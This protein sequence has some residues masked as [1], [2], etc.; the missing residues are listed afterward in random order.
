MNALG[1]LGSSAARMH[2]N[3]VAP[4]LPNNSTNRRAIN[5][6]PSVNDTHDY[7]GDDG[8]K[9]WA[10]GVHTL[11]M[12]KTNMGAAVVEVRACVQT[13]VRSSI[14]TKSTTMCLK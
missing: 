5:M 2:S 1:G 10:E 11:K 7:G 14:A 4:H 13:H 3:D 12:A 6:R 9:R 8:G